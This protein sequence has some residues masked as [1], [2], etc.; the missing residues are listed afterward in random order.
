MQKRY[1]FSFLKEA[2]EEDSPSASLALVM[3]FNE[4][5]SWVEFAGS[6]QTLLAIILKLI[7]RGRYVCEV[8]QLFELFGCAY[9]DLLVTTVRNFVRESSARDKEIVKLYC[10]LITYV[11]VHRASILGSRGC[12]ELAKIANDFHHFAPIVE[13]SLTA[14]VATFPNVAKARNWLLVGD[15][16][17]FI[18]LFKKNR[19]RF[20][21]ALFHFAV[22]V[23]SIHPTENWM[24]AFCNED[25]VLKWFPFSDKAPPVNEANV[26]SQMVNTIKG[27]CEIYWS[28]QNTCSLKPK[29]SR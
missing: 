6:K 21:S 8:L 26:K 15:A 5:D 9:F 10:D 22:D 1:L 7:V 11:S 24:A 4:F 29:D 16:D 28:G 12:L 27:P 23:V 13:L 20:K 25:A 19:F 17:G 14:H 2:A 18:H 3:L